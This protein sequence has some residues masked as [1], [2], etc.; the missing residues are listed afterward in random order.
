[1]LFA[2]AKIKENEIA[3]IALRKIGKSINAPIVIDDVSLSLIRRFPLATI[4]LEGVWLGS[5]GAFGLSDSLI[6]EEETLAKIEK[7]YVSVKTMPLFKGE[8]EIMRVGIKGVDFSYIVDTRGVSNFD[9]LINAKEEDTSDT[10]SVSLNVMLKELMLRDIHCNYYDSLRLAGARIVIPKAEVNGEIR[11]EYLHGSA[12]GVLKLSDCNYK[13]TNLYFMRETEVDFDVTY[14]EDSVDVK[15]LI[16][17]TDGADFNIAGSAVIKDTIEMDIHMQ[18]TKINIDEL[19]KYVPKEALE[20]IGLEKAAG[21][22]NMDALIKGFASDSIVP[23]VKMD[24]AMKNGHVQIAGYPSLK[25]ISF[26]AYLTNGEMRNNKTTSVSIRK[27]HAETRKS[28]VD[29]SFS[30]RDPDRKQYEINSGFEID[31]GE[32]KEYIPDSIISDAKG[33]LRARIAAKGFFPDSVGNDFI[34]YLLETS[35]LDLTFDNLFLAPDP[36]LSLDS[37]SGLLAYDLHHITARNLHVNVPLYSININNASFDARL[38]GRFSE[39]SNLGINLKSYQI[40]TDSCDFYGSAKIQNLKAPGFNITSNIRLNLREI[41]AMLP[42]TLVNKLSGEITAQIVSRGKFNPDSIPDQI[43]DLIFKNSEFRI[44][45][46]RVTADMPDTMMSVKKLSGKLHMKPDTLKINDTRGVY[47]G[48]D[49]S[50]DSTIIV[51]LYNS[52][53]MNKASKLYVEGRFNFGALDYAMFAPFMAGNA[54]TTITSAENTY[55]TAAD[56]AGSTATN[57]TY[58]IKG[59]LRVKSLTYN[60]AV[61]ENVSGLFNLT[62]S[63]Y[64]VDQLK[65]NGFG[66]KLNTSVRYFIKD[67][68]KIIWVKN[69][70]EK[71]NVIQLLEDFDNFKDFYEP[72]I[73]HENLSGILSSGFDGQVLFKGDSLIR[74]KLYV[75]GD[76]KIEKGGVYNYKPVKDMEQYLKGVGSL[77]RLEFKT[78]HS[79]VFIFQD[80]IY[81]PT[82]LVVSNKLDAKALGMQSFGEDYSYHFIVFLSDILTGKNTKLIKKQ[83]K[84]GDE[85]TSADMKGGTLVKSYSINGKSR[86]GLD[87]KSDQEKMRSKIKSSEG[88]LNVRFHPNVI[89]YDT[90]VK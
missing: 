77:D 85:I 66:G 29:M 38:S 25:N 82:T 36:T 62:D 32:I 76:I 11:D 17:S 67:E 72:S 71:M 61:V 58:S 69:R 15:E 80:A 63:L 52:V 87:N 49:F 60:K 34:D 56:S 75:R 33:M 24:I 22:L 45:F 40:S 46:D 81:V 70:I 74:N 50:I 1:M 31:L 5:P 20:D 57:Y 3:D 41:K 43:N 47:S 64:L 30:M 21:V 59:K 13:A 42:D 8:F 78:I 37:L 89:N 90:G 26:T 39:P 88:L 79:N 23:G 14:S 48:I 7:V 55:A 16:I 86:S 9:F 12:R 73:T 53:I 35:K 18:G 28:S 83:N 68:E 2:V 84:T 51:N 10:T 54:D 44:D 4:K 6:T 27:F 19:I 65:F